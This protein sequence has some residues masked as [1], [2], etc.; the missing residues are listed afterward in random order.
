MNN[1]KRQNSSIPSEFKQEVSFIGKKSMIYALGPIAHHVVGFIMIPVYTRFIS[2]GNYGA[3]ELI[4]IFAIIVSMIV[5]MGVADSMPR[6]YYAEKDPQK[7]NEVVS[8]IIIGFGILAIPIIIISISLSG[9][10]SSIVME[11]PKYRFLVQIALATVLF[12]MLNEIAFTYLRMLY[13][14]K[15]TVFVTTVELILG[16]SLNIWFVVFLRLGILGI[17]YSELI[18][19]I[20]FG[21]ILSIV[22]LRKVGI[23]V[24]STLL[25]RLVRFGFPLVPARIGLFLGFVANRFFLRWLGSPDPVQALTLVGLFSLGNKFAVVIDRFIGAPLNSFWGPRRM[26]LL[27]SD[28]PSA[29]ETVAR[30]CTYALMLSLYAALGLSA[31][32]ESLIGIVADPKYHGAHIVVPFLALTFVVLGLERH[33]LTGIIYA[34]KT[35]WTTYTSLLSMAVILLWNYIFVPKYG[36]IGAATSNLAGFAV[37]I[38]FIYLI[39]QRLFFIPFELQR[40]LLLFA[41]AFCLYV[42]SQYISFASLWLT[43]FSRI[44]LAALYPLALFFVG[45]YKRGELD[46]IF[47]TLRKILAKKS[48]HVNNLRN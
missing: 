14:A 9:I 21:T 24:S 12:N 10:L 46:F 38:T 37:R 35:M 30:I 34:R 28:N 36:L 32:I 5:S 3:L 33:F 48:L 43:L 25:W 44:G 17:F 4:G 47:E 2:P 31:G 11:E 18:I 19:G 23:H 22:I 41:T 20:L 6:Y 45:F 27:F 13:M 8:T 16:F 42:I 26:E 7:R 15:L 39:S 1:T 29:K 40:M